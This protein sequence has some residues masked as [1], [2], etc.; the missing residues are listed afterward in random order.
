MFLHHITTVVITLASYSIDFTRVGAVVKVIMD[1]ADVPLHAAKV[2]DEARDVGGGET[3]ARVCVCVCNV[4]GRG[5]RLYAVVWPYRGV[6]RCYPLTT[7][8]EPYSNS[9]FGYARHRP[10]PPGALLSPPPASPRSCACTRATRSW[11][12]V[13]LRCSRLRSSPCASSC[14][15]TNTEE[16]ITFVA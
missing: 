16:T 3:L 15:G 4:A 12:T 1:P 8:P 5:Q 9:L 11:P 2:R 10:P 6:V 13:S 7:S 14:M